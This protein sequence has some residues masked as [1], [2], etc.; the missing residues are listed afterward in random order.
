MRAR[1]GD[2]TAKSISSVGGLIEY[3][4]SG[5][6]T[7]NFFRQRDWDQDKAWLPGIVFGVG[8]GESEFLIDVY[9]LLHRPSSLL[10]NVFRTFLL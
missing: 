2:L 5:V 1:G 6:G 10:K 4:C 8:F 3:L 9:L 7:F